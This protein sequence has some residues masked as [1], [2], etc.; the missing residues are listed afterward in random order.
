MKLD[1]I[2]IMLKIQLLLLRKSSASIT[3][4]VCSTVREIIAVYLENLTKPLNTPCE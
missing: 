3:R 1:F 4:H 2:K